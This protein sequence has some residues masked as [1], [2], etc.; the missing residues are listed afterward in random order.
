LAIFEESIEIKCPVYKVFTYT[1]D[2]KSW[3]KWHSIIPEAEQT[4]QGTVEVGTTFKG[5]AYMMGVGMK[6]TAKATEY[7]PNSHFSKDITSGGMIIKQ[8]NTYDPVDGG[9]K[10]TILYDIKVRGLFKLFS[11]MLM[12][13]MRKD[14]SK[15]LSNLKNNLEAQP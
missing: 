11:P 2:A 9:V 5:I 10:F 3:P 15:S 4:S 7:E 12:N 14:L 6:W 1:I 8:H 13:L